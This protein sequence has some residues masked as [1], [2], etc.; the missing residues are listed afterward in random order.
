M[1]RRDFI[2]SSALLFGVLGSKSLNG[3]LLIQKPHDIFTT[4]SEWNRLLDLQKKLSKIQ[5]IVGFGKF[6]IISF[7]EIL[8]VASQTASI[9]D[10]TQ[11]ELEL[12]EK[13]YYEDPK[14][15]GFYGTQTTTQITK[16][17]S[18][19]EIY[20]VPKSGHYLFRGE[21][22]KNY[23]KIKKDVGKEI[24]LTSGIRNI[25]KQTA[26]YINKIV[27]LKGNISQAA[28]IIAPPA[29]TYH[30]LGDFDVGKD[31][32]GNRNFSDYFASTDEFKALVR[33]NYIDIRYG[34]NNTD[35]VIYEPWHIKVV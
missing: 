11:K 6:N 15:Y 4:E 26:L 30:T 32:L 33:L 14:K 18:Q 3:S 25:P 9:G 31:G 2:Y 7:D 12:F 13:L 5:K 28:R 16:N 17:I 24:I 29:Y 35:G 22:L 1:D 20:K 34:H 10:F 27:A 23:E 19:K 21:S 8:K